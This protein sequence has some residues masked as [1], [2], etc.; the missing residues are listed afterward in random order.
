M[1]KEL[2]TVETKSERI[3]RW[4]EKKRA[5]DIGEFA[6]QYT[7]LALDTIILLLETS[8]DE[9]V[10]LACA[11]EVLDRTMG[12]PAQAVLAEH[13]GTLTVSWLSDVA[14]GK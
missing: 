11:R 14:G 9:K 13:T 4:S 10:R 6:R 8:E 12:R 7:Q 2:V 3:R 1:S 5:Q